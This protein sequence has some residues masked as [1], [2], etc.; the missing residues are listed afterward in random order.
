MVSGVREGRR[1]RREDGQRDRRPRQAVPGS[2]PA[3][4]ADK[5]TPGEHWVARGNGDR[6][7]GHPG[8]GESLSECLILD[9]SKLKKP[10]AIY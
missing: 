8:R 5:E 1:R 3:G 6:R 9:T 7:S 10:V 2:L 4:N